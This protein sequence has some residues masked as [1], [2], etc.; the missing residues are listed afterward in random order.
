MRCAIYTRK[1]ADE[2]ADVQ[3]SSLESQRELCERYIESQ[4]AERWAAL[5]EYYD[6]GGYSGGNINRPALRRLIADIEARK[7]DIVVV[8]KIDRLSRSLHDFVGLVALFEEHDVTFVAI[9]QA[10]N[11]TSSIGRLTLNVLLSFAQFERELTGERLRDWFAGAR[12]RGLW[13]HGPAPYGYSVNEGKLHIRE[14]EAEVVRYIYG[15]YPTF[16]TATSLTRHL[17]A[18]GIVGRTGIPL[19]YSAVLRILNNRVYRGEMVHDGKSL[20]GIH[21]PIISEKHWQNAHAILDGGS[22]RGPKKGNIAAP[23]MLTGLLFGETGHALIHVFVL[24]KK[25][26]LNRYYVPSVVHSQGSKRY[27]PGTSSSD[28]YRSPELERAVLG[29]LDR[30]VGTPEASLRT[31]A[32]EMRLMRDLVSRIDIGAVEMTITL[33][34]GARLT[35]AVVGRIGRRMG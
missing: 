35:T 34:T 12:A 11:T 31:E 33:K 22:S 4:A 20:P 5:P 16:R 14:D 26:Y 1:S 13:M 10:F 25:R 21:E 15:H 30:L 19:S 9:T 6:D 3:F 7:S 28:R 8:Y 32:E 17:A 2:S 29:L 18:E 23:K 27:G 24:V